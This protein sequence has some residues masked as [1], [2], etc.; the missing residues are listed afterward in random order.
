MDRVVEG[1]VQTKLQLKDT[2]KDK[3]RKNKNGCN[4]PT[5]I[6]SKPQVGGG[7][8][9]EARV[10]K[11]LAVPNVRCPRRIRRSCRRMKSPTK[12][13]MRPTYPHLHK[14]MIICCPWPS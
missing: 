10:A 11:Q 6:T 1:G 12:V 5:K 9:A 14:H 2:N 4:R 8:E 3:R 7:V 13:L